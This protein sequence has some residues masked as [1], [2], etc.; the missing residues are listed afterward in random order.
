MVLSGSIYSRLPTTQNFIQRYEKKLKFYYF[1]NKESR[2]AIFIENEKNMTIC[3]W[4]DYCLF[5]QR[6]TA[7]FHS[8]SGSIRN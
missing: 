8:F 5:L 2:F 7:L 1:S 4:H 6:S 3:I